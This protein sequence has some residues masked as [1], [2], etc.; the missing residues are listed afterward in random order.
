M[1][2]IALHPHDNGLTRHANGKNNSAVAAAVTP[3]ARD[4]SAQ[5]V[6]LSSAGVIRREHE[7]G[8]HK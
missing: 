8:A 5:P 1:A 2:P 4:H 3:E 7:F 6:H